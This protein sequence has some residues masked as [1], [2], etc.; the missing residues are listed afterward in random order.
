MMDCVPRNL[1]A[2]P[3]ARLQRKIDKSST[4]KFPYREAVGS[5]RYLGLASR[6]DI[7]FLVGK[8]SQFFEDPGPDHLSALPRILA[9]LKGT[10]NHGICF[11]QSDDVLLGY[12]DSNFGGDQN[13]RR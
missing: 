8:L 12:C 13:N 9:Y 2:D 11:G 5:L 3:G 10:Q 7:S 1:P 4:E 6:P